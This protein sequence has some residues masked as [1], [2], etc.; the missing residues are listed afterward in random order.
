MNK[1]NRMRSIAWA[2]LI[3]VSTCGAYAQ[4]GV[5][6]GYDFLHGK[7]TL[8]VGDEGHFSG[9][10]RNHGFRAGLTYDFTIKGNLGL[11]TGVLYSYAAG[12]VWETERI[13]P[14]YSVYGTMQVRSVYQQLEV[15]IRV[16]YDLPV[17]NDFKFFVFG[18][19]V[20]GYTLS[21][22][23]K[24]WAFRVKEVSWQG[25]GLYP[26]SYPYN[27]YERYGLMPFEL[28]LGAGLGVHYKHYVLKF[29]Y[30]WGL[31]DQYTRG[32]ASDKVHHNQLNVSVGYVF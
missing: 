17:T 10:T 29:S 13:L 6:V 24:D 15:P 3:A 12:N 1:M 9:T 4:L 11:H 22:Q 26:Q 8:A 27:V 5:E 16:R 25:T 20:L 23:V 18:G 30:D 28:K 32:T 19:P 21:G 7:G 31:L 14:S 2:V